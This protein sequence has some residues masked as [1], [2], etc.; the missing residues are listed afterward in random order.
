AAR[1]H[2]RS[3]P[4]ADGSVLGGGRPEWPRSRD[5]SRRRRAD[6][7]E[8]NART[9][10]NRYHDAY[11]ELGALFT[12]RFGDFLYGRTT[13]ERL[14]PDSGIAVWRQREALVV[15]HGRGHERPS[16]YSALR[17]VDGDGAAEH[18]S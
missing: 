1:S 6:A 8:A 10:S 16:R 5:R 3:V 11:A 12:N 9:R 18:E 4:A 15:V 14:R 7:A 13:G 17:P 2:P